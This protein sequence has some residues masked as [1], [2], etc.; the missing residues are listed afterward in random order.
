[1]YHSTNLF[2]AI[3]L[4]NVSS[5]VV[6]SQKYKHFFN[7]VELFVEVFGM[8]NKQNHKNYNC[9]G[10]VKRDL[11]QPGLDAM[12][13]NNNNTWLRIG[14]ARLLI[15]GSKP[16][17]V[18]LAESNIIELCYFLAPYREQVG[19]TPNLRIVLEHRILGVPNS[20]FCR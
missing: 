7:I 4:F 6:K 14:R 20:N 13:I 16:A 15:F 18:R 2:Y 12:A 19:T 9:R 17:C 10:Y 3:L 8:I 1:M 11:K 5:T